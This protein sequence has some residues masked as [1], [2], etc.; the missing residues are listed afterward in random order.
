[1]RFADS[2]PGRSLIDM[3]PAGPPVGNTQAD[4]LLPVP[5]ESVSRDLGNNQ[6]DYSLPAIDKSVSMDV[7]EDCPDHERSSTHNKHKHGQWY[8]CALSRRT[9]SPLTPAFSSHR[10][11]VWG[12]IGGFEVPGV[13]V[14]TASDNP[15][16]AFS[17]VERHPILKNEPIH[18]I[19]PAALTLKAANGSVMEILGFIRF[20]LQLG[21]SLAK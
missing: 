16:V 2:V 12:R 4:V 10:V 9:R 14:D 21:T 13:T 20:D 19:P 8:A 7:N 17:F 1:M 11:D 3:C 18:A 6:V 5:S 15:C